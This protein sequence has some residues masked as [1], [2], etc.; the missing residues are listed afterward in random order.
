ML[1][2]N[3]VLYSGD[4]SMNSTENIQMVVTIVYYII[5]F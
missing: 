5:G 2:L 1:Y 3:F 4:G